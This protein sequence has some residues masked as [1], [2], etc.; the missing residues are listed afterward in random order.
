MDFGSFARVRSGESA[1]WFLTVPRTRWTFTRTVYCEAETWPAVED[2][3]AADVPVGRL[4]SLSR[5][6]TSCRSVKGSSSL[7]KVWPMRAITG[8]R[9]D[10]IVAL[11]V[12][13]R[14]AELSQSRKS[15]RLLYSFSALR[16]RPVRSDSQSVAFTVSLPRRVT[17]SGVGHPWRERSS[18]RVC[19]ITIIHG[20][21]EPGR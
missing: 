4:I 21:D 5:I 2:D 20:I 10:S 1:C 3:S 8:S 13:G 9:S 18:L 6:E 19:R 7:A 17:H 14:N 11:K 12:A 15:A 16:T